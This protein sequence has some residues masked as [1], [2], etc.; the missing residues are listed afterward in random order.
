MLYEVIT[1]P[2]TIKIDLDN[3]EILFSEKKDIEKLK[4]T[5]ENGFYIFDTG[6]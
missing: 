5:K 6:T 3:A 4:V 2:E 1:N